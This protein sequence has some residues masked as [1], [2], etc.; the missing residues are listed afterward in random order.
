MREC[1][2][3][4]ENN[5]QEW[6]SEMF[7]LLRDICH[8]GNQAKEMGQ[9]VPLEEI[10]RIEKEY[11]TILKCGYKQIPK[12]P[13]PAKKKRGKP[14]KSTAENLLDRFTIHK[15]AVLRSLYDLNVPFSNNRAEQDVRMI[16]VRQKVSG[17]FR[18]MKGA[19]I[20]TR[21]RGFISTIR[22]NGKDVIQSLS[23]AY[24]GRFNSSF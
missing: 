6:S 22:K 20:F 23:D 7:K 13:V 12:N 3:I 5:K 19:Q 14:A 18:T 9:P 4:H 11:D 15:P 21:I 2:S 16:K 24:A 1:R 17:S 8:T 10:I